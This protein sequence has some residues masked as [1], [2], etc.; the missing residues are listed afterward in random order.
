MF[1]FL[2]LN[3]NSNV[4]L[5]YVYSQSYFYILLY[6]LSIVSLSFTLFLRTISFRVYQSFTVHLLTTFLCIGSVNPYSTSSYTF[7][8]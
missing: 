8:L 2:P 1:Y 5:W 3:S 6:I 4:F 7:Y